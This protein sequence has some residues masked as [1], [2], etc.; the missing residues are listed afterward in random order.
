M[1]IAVIVLIWIPGVIPVT[2]PIKIPAAPPAKTARI[3]ALLIF[4]R[5]YFYVKNILKQPHKLLSL[6]IQLS[7]KTQS[8]NNYWGMVIDPATLPLTGLPFWVPEKALLLVFPCK[9]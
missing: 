2:I 9:T 1:R 3:M 8:L 6:F 5:F 4:E 7:K